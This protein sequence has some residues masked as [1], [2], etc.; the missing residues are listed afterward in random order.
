MFAQ[1]HE[2]SIKSTHFVL[3]DGSPVK[4]RR[5]SVII[6]YVKNTDLDPKHDPRMKLGL[7]LC[8]KVKPL[9]MVLIG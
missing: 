2:S 8:G 4:M 6:V 7:L 3:G 9:Q 1:C 5:R